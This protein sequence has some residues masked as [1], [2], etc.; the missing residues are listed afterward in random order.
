MGYLHLVRT[1][2]HWKLFQNFEALSDLKDTNKQELIS[3]NTNAIGMNTN[4]PGVM[5]A[6][7]N[8][9]SKDA[10]KQDAVLL[11]QLEICPLQAF[12]MGYLH[13]VRT[14]QHWKLFQNFE[15]LSDLDF[16]IKHQFP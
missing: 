1:Q 3:A 11:D 12:P 4:K 5:S 8:T 10:N 2:Q 15:A 16:Q 13:L 9:I 7:T 14:Q 6:N